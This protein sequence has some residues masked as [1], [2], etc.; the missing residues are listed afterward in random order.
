VC[1]SRRAK[2]R[3][4]QRFGALASSRGSRALTSS[5]VS[6]RGEKAVTTVTPIYVVRP[7]R[8]APLIL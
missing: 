6:V 1:I 4:V 3:C 5:L 2:R 7:K 8:R